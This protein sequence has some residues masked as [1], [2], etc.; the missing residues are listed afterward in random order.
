MGGGSLTSMKWSERMSMLL[1]AQLA[2]AQTHYGD[3]Q[4]L[5]VANPRPSTWTPPTG[6]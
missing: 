6:P 4:P 3:P 2:K 1:T 5:T